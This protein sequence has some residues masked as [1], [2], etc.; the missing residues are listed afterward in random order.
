[1]A[2][3]RFAPY[4][5][6][7]IEEHRMKVRKW[8]EAELA[9]IRDKYEE[10]NLDGLGKN[11]PR[12]LIGKMAKEGLF[13][14]FVPKKYGGQELSLLYDI[15]TIEEV[16][17]VCGSFSLLADYTPTLGTNPIFT[18]GTE[19]QKKKYLPQIVKGEMLVS[20]GLTEPKW[21]SDI[22]S[23]ETTA[24][25]EGDGYIINGE[26]KFIVLANLADL[27][28]VFAKT[29]PEAGA[30]GITVFLIDTK[31]EGISFPK[32]EKKM[33]LRAI[34]VSEIKIENVKA[35]PDDILG[36][37]EQEG[38][39]IY[40]AL[41][42]LDHGR[43]GVAAQAL[44]T[45]QAALEQAT[46]FASERS[47]FG[48][49]VGNFEAVQW[50]LADMAIKLDAARLLTYRAAYFRDLAIKGEM[51]RRIVTSPVAMAKCYA[52]E[53]ATWA[54]HRAIQILGGR[55]FMM[56]PEYA[57]VKELPMP[58]TLYRDCRVFEIYEGTN[59]VQRMVIAREVAQLYGK[60]EKK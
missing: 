4:V 25:K 7:E 41:D 1:L 32:Q 23:L 53:V 51:D 34:P 21:G 52:T 22:V 35:S 10:M 60:K 26:K 42:T 13:A 59:E 37:P 8:A 58:E 38:R 40:V 6:P 20:F 24:K 50:M 54:A 5:T 48:Q 14:A 11:F 33:G 36:G 17:R 57:P 45:T 44:G 3:N 18:F 47:Q 9:P 55:G 43:C 27:I 2:M 49:P 19:E 31:R 46:R 28:V 15:I 29:Q 56:D 12:E 16:A 30:R 39:G